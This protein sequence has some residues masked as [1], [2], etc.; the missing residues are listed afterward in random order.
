MAFISLL[1]ALIL[2]FGPYVILLFTTKLKEKFQYKI[3]LKTLVVFV[4]CAIG[5]LLV[6]LLIPPNED[7]L[8]FT[9]LQGISIT[10][11]FLVDLFGLAVAQRRCQSVDA[12]I[13][14]V[15]FSW[16]FYSCLFT[17]ALPI[18]I[19]ANSSE[20]RFETLIE[21]LDASMEILKY[22]AL[23]IAVWT[24]DPT[25]TSRSRQ[26]TTKSVTVILAVLGV[27]MTESYFAS[28]SFYKF[29]ASACALI[30]FIVCFTVELKVYNKHMNR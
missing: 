6:D 9:S 10:L 17:R 29:Y 27:L 2:T 1:N 22:L 21:S 5:R 14:S 11:K 19:S 30:T 25:W 13:W 7:N 8:E 4:L 23:G 15:G 20:F 12:R 26:T 28:L 3:A 16:A 24:L 18:V